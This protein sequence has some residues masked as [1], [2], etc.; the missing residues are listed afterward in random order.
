MTIGDP[1]DS[2]TSVD[3]PS[4]DA[5]DAGESGLSIPDAASD[6]S[7][8]DG[9]PV[10]LS[11]RMPCATSACW[12]GT[13]M[14]GACGSVTVPEDFSTGRYA[15]HRYA[16]TVTAGARVAVTVDSTGGTWSPALIV[17]APSGA[18]IYD[19][20]RGATG[21]DVIVEPTASG[22]G[23]ATASVFVTA[24]VDALVHVFVTSWSVVDSGFTG[25]APPMDARYTLRTMGNCPLGAS[26][27]PVSRTAI[28]SFGSG[29]FTE[30]ESSD[31]T[32]PTYTPYKRD[33]R[34]SHH[35]YDIYVPRG[36]EVVAS[37]SGTIVQVVPTDTGDCGRTI[38]LATNS[39]VT[40]HYCHLDRVDVT[41]GT[42]VM[43]GQ[44]LGLSGMTGNAN[45]PHVHF[46]YLNG[47]DVIGSGL[48][49]GGDLRSVA[50]NA[51]IDGLCM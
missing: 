27:C 24:R 51:Y 1:I 3:A 45:A 37:Q 40:F 41:T 28:T 35:G 29:Y 4:R 7:A 25:S 23:G 10:Q 33:S 20:E 46:G 42:V 14:L 19:G 16:L 43:V 32:S 5:S 26:V 12:L 30:F 17:L 18:T 36:T 9:R 8:P 38:N 49:S 15:V 21:G 34:T 31:R 22:R 50:V 48:T 44:R 39:G 2:G 11:Q 6:A 47:R 13:R